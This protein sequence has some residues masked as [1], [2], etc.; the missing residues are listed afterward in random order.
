MSAA[1]MGDWSEVVRRVSEWP[2]TRRM[3]LARQILETL[4]VS[5]TPPAPTTRGLSAAEI[6]ALL[7]TDRPPPDDATVAQ[8][9]DEH[10]AEKYG[11]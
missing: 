6:Q 3:A 7:A 9:I 2:P 11:R 1:S 4:P 8:W 5:D 10:R